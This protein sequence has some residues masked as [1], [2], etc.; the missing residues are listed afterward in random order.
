MLPPQTLPLDVQPLGGFPF[1]KCALCCVSQD[2]APQ[3]PDPCVHWFLGTCEPPLGQW[4]AIA[5]STSVEGGFAQFRKPLKLFWV[6]L[7]SIGVS[8]S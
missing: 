8:A 7:L 4:L 1:G 3:V 2:L 5:P 6:L